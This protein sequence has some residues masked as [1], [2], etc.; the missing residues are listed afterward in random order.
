MEV[1]WQSNREL[2]HAARWG[3]ARRALTDKSLARAA[4]LA[5]LAA[6][7]M[8]AA[9]ATSMATSGIRIPGHAIL[10][11]TLPIVLGVSLVPRR[12]A[13]TVMSLAAA[14]TFLAM[15]AAGLGLP[16]AAASIGL[17]CL[18]PATDIALAGAAGGWRLYLRFAFAGLVANLCAFA[19]RI[20]FG[21]SAVAGGHGAGGGMDSGRALG[22][23]H[24]PGAVV[25]DFWLPAL[26]SFALCGIA[27]GLTC[28]II[29]FRA[30]PRS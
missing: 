5:L 8:L 4:D 28:G 22:G 10:R 7:G 25:E 2:A 1:L 13:G 30:R 18:G 20:S 11:G 23:M 15:R 14:A 3:F 16:N 24:G 21:A 12:A 9:L 27:A 19:V 6:L 29:A 17:L 26:F